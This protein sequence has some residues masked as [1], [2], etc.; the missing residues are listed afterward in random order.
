MSDSE[1]GPYVHA[2]DA[3][4]RLQLQTKPDRIV[5]ADQPLNAEVHLLVGSLKYPLS[6]ESAHCKWERV[7]WEAS[8]WNDLNA[9]MPGIDKALEFYGRGIQDCIVEKLPGHQ[10]IR[11]GIKID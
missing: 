11:L 9:F 5:S 10:Q 1:C 8:Q 7:S 6:L 4:L 2:A 3:I